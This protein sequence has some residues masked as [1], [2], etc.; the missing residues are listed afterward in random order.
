MEGGGGGAASRTLAASD[1]PFVHAIQ[2]RV[3]QVY[4][5]LMYMD[6][7]RNLIEEQGYGIYERIDIRN[8]PPLWLAF[9]PDP[10][11][12]GRI[13][14]KVCGLRVLRAARSLAL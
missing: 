12:S 5:G 2:D 6:F 13:H 4:E 11:D 14:S 1:C 8:A 10:S 9:C 7:D 3:A